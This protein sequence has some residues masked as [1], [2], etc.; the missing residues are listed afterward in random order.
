MLKRL[1]DQVGFG[2]S[3]R[4]AAFL[5]LGCLVVANF[6]I[7]SRVPPPGRTKG[8]RFLDIEAFKELPFCLVC[9]L[10]FPFSG[11]LT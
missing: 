9:V 8:T 4:A 7:R 10:L 6:L 3:V 1:F 11:C 5:M 2:W